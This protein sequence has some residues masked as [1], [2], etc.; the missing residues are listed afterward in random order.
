MFQLEQQFFSNI[1]YS[2]WKGYTFD[3]SVLEEEYQLEK[4]S[5]QLRG[6][7]LTSI[8]FIIYAIYMILSLGF[9]G[10]DGDD[11]FI[12]GWVLI[13]IVDIMSSFIAIFSNSSQAILY[14]K[15]FK[16]VLLIIGMIQVRIKLI[17]TLAISSNFPFKLHW[18]C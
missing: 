7:F 13:L 3:N 15:T 8:L 10:G 14:F 4:N 16:F 6:F 2:Y 9:Y 18:K 12:D 1:S 17:L 11:K 5:E